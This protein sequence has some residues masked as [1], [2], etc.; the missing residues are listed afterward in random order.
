MTI[1]PATLFALIAAALAALG[2]W[3][4]RRLLLPEWAQML[5]FALLLALVLLAG[6]LVRLP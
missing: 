5:I 2:W 1:G 4:C 6:P 3:T